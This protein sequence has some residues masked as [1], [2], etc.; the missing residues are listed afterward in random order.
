MYKLSVFIG[1][2][3]LAAWHG[4]AARPRTNFASRPLS[5]RPKPLLSTPTQIQPTSLSVTVKSKYMYIIGYLTSVWQAL[6]IY[7]LSYFLSFINYM[8]DLKGR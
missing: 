5:T 8:I 6:P 7:F 4:G 3:D 1:Y 2:V